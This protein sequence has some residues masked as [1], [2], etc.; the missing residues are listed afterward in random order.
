MLTKYNFN[1]IELSMF[2]YTFYILFIFFT[3]IW[4]Q[5]IYNN[6][7]VLNKLLKFFYILPFLTI[8]YGFKQSTDNR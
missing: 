8:H 4:N 5:K 2:L 6:F 1:V 7:R 3:C